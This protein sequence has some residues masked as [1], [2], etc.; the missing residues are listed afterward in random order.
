MYELKLRPLKLFG[1]MLP[2]KGTG[3]A[4]GVS[5]GILKTKNGATYVKQ[6]HGNDLG[7]DFV[8]IVRFHTVA[9]VWWDTLSAIP[10]V[11]AICSLVGTEEGHHSLYLVSA[12]CIPVERVYH[13]CSSAMP[14]AVGISS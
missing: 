3:F 4:R 7:A 11:L 10:D 5:L 13:T 14:P 9:P 1:P 2:P 6:I 12:T 8:V